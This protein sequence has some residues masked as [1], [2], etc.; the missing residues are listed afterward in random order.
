MSAINLKIKNNLDIIFVLILYLFIGLILINNYKY[1]LNA[2]GISYITITQKYFSGDLYGAINGYWG[3]L[4]SWLM[5]PLLFFSKTP[6]SIIY[7]MKL[8]S[9]I[10]GFLTI[11]GVRLLISDFEIEKMIKNAILITLIPI[12]L[13][14]SLTI[15]TPDL[16]ITCILIYY[17]YF[18][19]HPKYINSKF[20]GL[21]C[22]MTG[23]LAFL[24]KS[25][26]LPFFLAHFIIFNLFF[27]FKN[28]NKRDKILNNLFIGLIIFLVISG[29]W[30][31]LI[32]DKYG[33]FTI[34][35]AGEYNHN[36]IG[37]ESQGQY[38]DFHGL[39]KPPNESAV[40]AWEDP[41]YFKMES[42]SPFE[43]W[44]YLQYQ[45]KTLSEN[46]ITLITIIEIYSILSIVIFIAAIIL[47]FKSYI[48]NN[49]KDKL[50]Y[51]TATILL[52][53]GG[54]SLFSVESRY[55]WLVYILLLIMGSYM[56]NLLFKNNYW[57]NTRKY[58]LLILLI[59]SFCIAPINALVIDFNAGK[60]ISDFTAGEGIYNLSEKLVN[61]YNLHGNIASNDN[62]IE[63]YVITFYTKN[64]YYGKSKNVNDHNQLKN[65]LKSND[66]D[67]YLVWG[68]SKENDYLSKDFKEVTNGNIADL[69]IYSLKN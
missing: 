67:Y 31:A 36:I 59:V 55:L 14:F 18:I 2:D 4:L 37:P 7:S 69:R 10:T 8:L 52:Y 28:P 16:L 25:Y 41:S 15:T 62:Y 53:S 56:L 48:N 43:S 66:I 35:T 30:I 42:W 26:A 3:P 40:S 44:E 45:L 6:S 46:I 33:K 64:K 63:S 11:I 54:Y 20:Y 12:I 65:E 24:T 60:E 17:L 1:L 19:Y 39:I 34:G 27:Y 21:I 57:N 58:I 61:N 23:S 29:V 47:I 49:S 5:T 68:D 9:L 32:S 50:I 51:L 13:Y 22:G 38:Y